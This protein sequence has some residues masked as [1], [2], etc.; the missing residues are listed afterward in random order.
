MWVGRNY[1]FGGVFWKGYL[2]KLFGRVILLVLVIKLLVVVELN[3]IVRCRVWR[4][5]YFLVVCEFIGVDY[6]IVFVVG[7][8]V[9]YLFL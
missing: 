2:L 8:G 5:C 1:L 7:S 9:W 6:S 3:G 4:W